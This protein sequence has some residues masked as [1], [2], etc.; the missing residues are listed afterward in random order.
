MQFKQGTPVFTASGADVGR[1]DRV[2]LDPHTDEVAGV[3]V[4]KGF[5]FTEDKVVPIDLVFQAFEDRVTLRQGI[6]DTLKNLATFEE[7]HYIPLEDVAARAPT[8]DYARSLYWYPP[9]GMGA[10]YAGTYPLPIPHYW[11]ETD[12]NIPEGTIALKEGARVISNDEKHV[13]NV[14]RVFVD[15]KTDKITHFLISQGLFFKARKIVPTNWV[16]KVTEDEVYLLVS[17]ELLN[18]LH[19]YQ[20]PVQTGVTST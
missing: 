14:E 10:A 9:I 3:V 16:D 15:S 1:I 6:G 8:V 17:S 20:E 7:T 18:S 11:V 4:R 5:L 19:D 13:G 12:Q 2:V